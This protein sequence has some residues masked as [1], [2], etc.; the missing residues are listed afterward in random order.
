[1]TSLNFITHLCFNTLHYL[2]SR[3]TI[4][5]YGALQSHFQRRIHHNQKINFIPE[6]GFHKYGRLHTDQLF[7]P[8]P[9][10]PPTK[11]FFH[12]WMNNFIHFLH[13]IRMTEHIGCQQRTI[14]HTILK[15]ILTDQRTKFPANHRV[16]LRDTLCFYI[17]NINRNS[18]YSK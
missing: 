2:F 7:T 8:E 5:L 9:G 1:M 11:I 10:S 3:W 18:H 14:Q 4:P 17:W 12:L 6:T 13:T 16:C 15:H